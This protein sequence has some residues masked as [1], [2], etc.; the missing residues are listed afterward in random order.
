MKDIRVLYETRDGIKINIIAESIKESC[1]C[2]KCG[3]IS[4]VNHSRYTRKL[5]RGSLEGRAIAQ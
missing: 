4:S 1:C 2:P 5:A 3:V